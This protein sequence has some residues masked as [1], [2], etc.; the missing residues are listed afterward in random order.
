MKQ[1]Y[2]GNCLESTVPRLNIVVICR[3]ALFGVFLLF[4]GL[5]AHAQTTPANGTTTFNTIG[6]GAYIEYAQ[7]SNGSAGFTANNVQSSGWNISGHTSGPDDYVIAGENWGGG[8]DGG[9]VYLALNSG[10]AMITSMR[11]KANDGKLF[12]LNTIDLGYDVG[13]ANINFTIK[14]YR[15]GIAVPGAS[16]AVPSF[17][18]FG[19]GGG[20]RRGINIAANSNFKGVDE[21]RIT[22]S[23]PG[24]L[25]ALDVDNINATNFRAVSF[26]QI[27]PADIP[28]FNEGAFSKTIA[29]HLFT[30]TPAADNWVAYNND[31][32]SE[33]F[34]GLYSYDYNTMDGTET[35]IS[36]PAG[37][38]FDLSSFQYISDRG[39]VN[40]SVTLT[41]SDNSTDTKSYMLTGNSSV[42]T[43]T[44]FTTAA[45][46]V[47]RIRLITDELL[48]YNNFEL[49]D[50]NAMSTLPLR[51][52]QFTATMQEKA[53][54]LNWRTATEQGTKD[55]LV[56][57]SI[58][59]REWQNIGT[60]MAAGVSGGEQVYS[61][62][63]D[64]P[65][66]GSNAYR[67]LQRD[68]DGRG[69]YSR[70]VTVNI[71]PPAEWF[72]AYPNPAPG[73]VVQIKLKSPGV[74]SVY[75]SSGLFMLKKQLP[76]GVSILDLS[77]F[78][79]GA[80]TVTVKDRSLV[81]LVR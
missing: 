68:A 30:F 76:A 2:P 56:Q 52:L 27:I 23:S 77:S 3:I 25:Y 7:T 13:G 80:Y 65:A 38:T 43:F 40:L 48:Y 34:G 5:F 55:F 14:G 22:P 49:V 66:N 58:E 1:F 54:I 4:Y 17:A 78:G 81:L 19:N 53:V 42:Q 61:F 39:T 24:L 45:N 26:T 70:V 11:F 32:G 50:I 47:K 33:G 72:S 12:D 28:D 75:N 51:W 15:A 29:G 35:T 79:K 44:G 16:F 71:N 20:W 73:G 64:N 60:V 67:L 31:V 41:F 6:N 37:Y 36:A 63:H 74:V 8:S 9:F 62:Q 69:S 59:G 46:N 21:F 10:G 18:A 57:H